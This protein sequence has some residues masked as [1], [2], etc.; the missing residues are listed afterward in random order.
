[1]EPLRVTEVCRGNLLPGRRRRI[2]CKL[3]S[4]P[5]SMATRSDARKLDT[6]IP[7]TVLTETE[8]QL[9]GEFIEGRT[10]ADAIYAHMK[11]LMAD[12]WRTEN[13][14]HPLH[15]T[16]KNPE[17][18]AA[19]IEQ[20]RRKRERVYN[21]LLSRKGEKNTAAELF[22]AQR[23]AR[24][25]NTGNQASNGATANSADPLAITPSALVN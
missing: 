18:I 11:L 6:N 4:S 17:K 7:E 3:L 10:V 9:K 24:L 14:L 2:R 12:K 21:L 5:S 23:D 19:M 8:A 22:V 13:N 15:T 20:L 25:E 1:M 16:E